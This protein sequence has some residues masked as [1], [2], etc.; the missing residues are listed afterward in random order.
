MVKIGFEET[1][2]F[3]LESNPS[4]VN[5]CVILNGTTEREVNVHVI[6]VDISATSQFITISVFPTAIFEIF[7]LQVEV[8]VTS[9]SLLPFLPSLLETTILS[10]SLL[11]S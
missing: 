1:I 3:V 7:N 9:S 6:A 11:L 8:V 2:Y 5:V 10:V 4:S